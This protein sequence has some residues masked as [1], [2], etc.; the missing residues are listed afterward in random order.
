MAESVGEFERHALLDWQARE[1]ERQPLAVGFRI[2]S[3][4]HADGVLVERLVGDGPDLRAP[5]AF[6]ARRYAIPMIQVDSWEAP[7]N[8][9]A[10]VQITQKV[11]LMTSSMSSRRT[12]MRA[13]RRESRW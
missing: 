8:S 7:R 3:G 11:S 4:R 9:P 10:L 2:V 6:N 5:S 12:D 1:A 13:S